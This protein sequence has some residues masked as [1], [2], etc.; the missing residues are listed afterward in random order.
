MIAPALATPQIEATASPSELLFG[1]FAT[2]SLRRKE[3][4]G[5]LES[6]AKKA[7]Q[8]FESGQLVYFDAVTS[9]NQC[10]L[11]ALRIASLYQTNVRGNLK[12]QRFL[13]LCFLL[14]TCFNRNKKLLSDLLI[15]E[16]GERKK[17]L[18]QFLNSKELHLAAKQSLVLNIHEFIID[19]LIRLNGHEDSA[20]LKELARMAEERD[21]VNGLI[22]YPKF[23][24]VLVMARLAE[25]ARI[26]LVQ[27]VKM[28]C[29]KGVHTA[30]IA[31][32]S[33]TQA[34]VIVIEGFA[35]TEYPNRY[36]EA[37]R[38]CPEGLFGTSDA[39][40]KHAN[41]C[42]ACTPCAENCLDFA[43]SQHTSM[44]PVMILKA[45][46]ADFTLHIQP[47]LCDKYFLKENTKYPELCK[48][49][50]EHLKMA[51][52]M[53][54]SLQSGKHFVVEHCYPDIGLY[55]LEGKRLLDTKPE[56]L[57]KQRGL[58]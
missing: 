30:C 21:L 33:D 46:G 8:L 10:Q 35:S 16:N 41:G 9:N 20:V 48:L 14:C 17:A 37:R 34:P 54:L 45:A 1:S 36:L 23:A 6:I 22:T 56:E 5:F 49:F 42:A 11:V 26:S 58:T 7:I 19:S 28:Q 18:N 53:G 43:R 39:K 4:E 47:E 3:A 55:T 29:P 44:S 38:E 32:S 2:E 15:P 24:G 31:G 40:K 51:Q 50:H 13:V 57:M 25:E 12:D 52:T 27:K